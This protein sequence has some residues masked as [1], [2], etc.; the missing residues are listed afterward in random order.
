LMQAGLIRAF[1][2]AGAWGGVSG[3]L[4]ATPELAQIVQTAESE[5]PES[6][7][8]D[9][10]YG[11]INGSAQNRFATGLG[12]E[13]ALER[14]RSALLRRPNGA[15]IISTTKINNL[16]ALAALESPV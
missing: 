11:A 15:V 12:N 6:F 14:L 8:P 4:T 10:T 1:G 9:I 2:L 16:R 7:P 13:V 3:L 5:W